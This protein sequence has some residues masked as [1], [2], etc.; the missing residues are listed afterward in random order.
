MV[1][2]IHCLL[3]KLNISLSSLE[4]TLIPSQADYP[5]F[6]SYPMGSIIRRLSTNPYRAY[7]V[8]STR[9]MQPW[10]MGSF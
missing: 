8:A 7:T 9:V 10:I 4:N 2:I 6:S 3:K 5:H 1:K